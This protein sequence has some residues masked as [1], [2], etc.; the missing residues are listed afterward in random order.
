M[1][2]NYYTPEQLE[3]LK[4]RRE[5][6]G[7][8]ADDIAKKGQ[9]DWAALIAD[10]TT[11][12]KAGIDPADPKVQALE[13]RRQA[14]VNAF[15]G[16]DKGLEQSLKRMW[17]EQGDKLSAQFGYDPGVMAYLAKVAEAGKSQGSK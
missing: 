13:Q 4:K 11:A 2:E 15:T 5:E 17:T 8:T 14:L 10:Y 12:M 16:G 3:Y 9:A 6:M 1:V 7:P